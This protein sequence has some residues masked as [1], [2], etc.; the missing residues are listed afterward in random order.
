MKKKTKDALDTGRGSVSVV[1]RLV[2]HAQFLTKMLQFAV[3]ASY[4][5][6]TFPVMVG[7]QKL[8]CLFAGRKHLGGVGPYFHTLADGIYTGSHQASCAFYLDNTDTACADFVDL[9]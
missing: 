9:F 4:T 2:L 7:K 5:G 1:E 8:Q 6:K 3:A